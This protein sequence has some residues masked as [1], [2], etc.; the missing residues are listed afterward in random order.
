MDT[1]QGDDDAQLVD[2]Q[3]ASP[4]GMSALQWLLSVPSAGKRSQTDID[5]ALARDRDW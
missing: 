2:Q 4:D 3:A 5:A 1:N